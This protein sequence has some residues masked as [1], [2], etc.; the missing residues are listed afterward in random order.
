M[1]SIKT[2][3]AIHADYKFTVLSSNNVTRAVYSF[4]NNE[5]LDSGLQAYGHGEVFNNVEFGI[6]S[7][8]TNTSMSGVISPVHAYR[9]DTVVPV[10][11][12]D[13]DVENKRVILTSVYDFTVEAFPQ[14]NA[15]ILTIYEFGIKGLSR[16]YLHDPF[17]ELN[18]LKIR[19]GDKV[20][21]EITFTHGYYTN[22]L[23]S[24]LG[25]TTFGERIDYTTEVVLLNETL[26]VSIRNVDGYAIGT[27]LEIFPIKEDIRELS[28]DEILFPKVDP[29]QYPTTKCDEFEYRIDRRIIG[30]CPEDTRLYG[31]ILRDN[32][33]DVGVLLR[34]IQPVL[35]AKDKRY[36]VQGFIKWNRV[37]DDIDDGFKTV[38]LN[39]YEETMPLRSGFI[40]HNLIRPPIIPEAVVEIKSLDNIIFLNGPDKE[41][42]PV[43]PNPTIQGV[44]G[45]LSTIDIYGVLLS[46]R[47]RSRT[48]STFDLFIP[49]AQANAA[50]MGRA[51]DMDNSYDFEPVIVA[52][53][54]YDD[55][56]VGQ[57]AWRWDLYY[58]YIGKNAMHMLFIIAG[59]EKAKSM[60]TDLSILDDQVVSKATTPWDGVV[61]VLAADLLQQGLVG[62]SGIFDS[63]I[64]WE[65]LDWAYQ[66]PAPITIIYNND[67]DGP[68]YQDWVNG[69]TTI[70]LNRR[71]L[72]CTNNIDSDTAK[73]LTEFKVT[74]DT[75][76]HQLNNAYMFVGH[77]KYWF[78][79]SI[80]SN[81]VALD[82]WVEQ[83][84]LRV[85]R[86]VSGTRIS[87]TFTRPY[88]TANSQY[89]DL[90]FSGTSEIQYSSDMT[91][92]IDIING[93]QGYRVY[94]KSGS[95]ITN[96]LQSIDNSF[97][98]AGVRLFQPLPTYVYK[99]RTLTTTQAALFFSDPSI[100]K[101]LNT[102]LFTI[103]FTNTTYSVV[104]Q[105]TI[106][107]KSP[108][109]AGPKLYPAIG[110]DLSK[111]D[112][113]I[114]D[115]MVLIT[116]P[117]GISW[118]K[119][120]LLAARTTMPN[121]VIAD[122]LYFAYPF[123]ILEGNQIIAKQITSD[124]YN[125]EIN[126][127]INVEAILT[128]PL[129]NATVTPNPMTIMVG[130]TIN[131]SYT[132][133][134]PQAN[135]IS[136]EWSII[137]P[138]I[139]SVS[140][141]GAVTGLVPGTTTLRLVLNNAIIATSTV[142]VVDANVVIS[143]ADAP[144]ITSCLTMTGTG[145]GVTVNDVEIDPAMSAEDV[146][147]YFRDND[148]FRIVN[149]QDFTDPNNATVS[150]TGFMTFVGEY[151]IYYNGTLVGKDIDGAD[152]FA[153]L[154]TFDGIQIIDDME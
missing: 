31:F 2:G 130:E 119:A 11:N 88:T 32:I 147:T 61:E 67:F 142:N 122:T 42:F 13:W 28:S 91:A 71:F 26:P 23:T 51:R 55:S 65:R 30:Y 41:P 105:N 75:R 92:Y 108:D 60:L 16:I 64:E 127:A 140:S 70:T 134:P 9:L 27:P 86:T 58:P 99:Y 141:A 14:P 138:F 72:D 123:Q 4:V 144:S 148:S 6:S 7:E 84:G 44:L 102:N 78:N 24:T 63:F 83:Y 150:E 74:F 53:A 66:D 115:D 59:Y 73:N 69:Q 47:P 17:Q 152:V 132:H 87:F 40:Q 118:T 95:E 131:A 117:E 57:N 68:K 33:R 94:N 49:D 54:N 104:Y 101:T 43:P 93:T 52:A 153:Q 1:L 121:R 149:C 146:R 109:L 100:I 89:I 38:E 20:R 81:Q 79:D 145:F 15:G 3:L 21:V 12:F 35:V 34:F 143:C 82:Q 154:G 136:S 112:G 77:E 39:K 110:I 50:I 107:W 37:Y 98:C 97:L 96:N 151:D 129:E 80:F 19:Q 62:G 126:L 128:Y 10:N 18:G 5:L 48:P 135:I 103:G 139:A 85:I 45:T 46:N 8:S 114:A 36:E 76:V 111:I 29:Y 22:N 137:D 113:I 124:F 133:V 116:D 125:Q 56:I 106:N 120:Q 90:Y 25:E